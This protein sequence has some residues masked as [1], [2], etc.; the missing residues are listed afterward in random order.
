V[1]FFFNDLQPA[2]R[3][4]LRRTLLERHELDVAVKFEADDACYAFSNISYATG[5][6]DPGKRLEGPE[7]LVTIAVT[8]LGIRR[9]EKR[10]LLI[11][12]GPKDIMQ[13]L[14]WPEDQR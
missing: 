4:P 13:I 6:R 12:G 14:P 8:G 7:I 10:F 3:T 11:P 1:V 5:W 2:V 9:E